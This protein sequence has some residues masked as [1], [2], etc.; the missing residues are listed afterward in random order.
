VQVATATTD[1]VRDGRHAGLSRLHGR[2]G[3][4]FA[5][6]CAS[7]CWRSAAQHTAYPERL[8]KGNQG[9]RWY[10][11]F[12][13]DVPTPAWRLAR[14][15]ERD[16]MPDGHRQPHPSRSRTAPG[17]R[18]A[19]DN[20]AQGRRTRDGPARNW[21]WIKAASMPT[22]RR[23]S[24]RQFRPAPRTETAYTGRYLDHS[25]A[26][27]LLANGSVYTSILV[28]ATSRPDRPRRVPKSFC[29]A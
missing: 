1:R 5:A 2:T 14:L 17:F 21:T 16:P 6:E 15:C 18:S 20:P 26:G 25:G 9:C 24:R 28:G 10:A 22:A 3:R 29:W 12:C 23:R 11:E 13:G 27:R 7:L 8:C 19:G 4:V